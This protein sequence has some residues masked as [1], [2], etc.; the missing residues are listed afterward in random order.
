[1][2]EKLYRV[3]YLRVPRI[4]RPARNGTPREPV[5]QACIALRLT[6][7]TALLRHTL[8]SR[9]TT[10]DAEMP[11]CVRNFGSCHYHSSTC[12][13]FCR[14][15]A[16]LADKLNTIKDRFDA[17]KVVEGANTGDVFFGSAKV[18]QPC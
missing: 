1:M 13:K 12:T 15:D 10:Q 6:C 2:W 16:G 7:S 4:P 18:H 17:D 11:C 14:R 9:S 8:S 3:L 5:L